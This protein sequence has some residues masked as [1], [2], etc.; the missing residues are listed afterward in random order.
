MVK[1]KY[2]SLEEL[3]D[4]YPAKGYY[5]ITEDEIH[6]PDKELLYKLVYCHEYIH[7]LRKDKLTTKIVANMN[8]FLI[9]I[10][11]SSVMTIAFPFMGLLVAFMLLTVMFSYFYEEVYVQKKMLKEMI[12]NGTESS[13]E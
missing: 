8:L 11:A 3:M 4:I 5:D 6:V 13:N 10:T 1:V 7:H 2:I 12:V 9:L